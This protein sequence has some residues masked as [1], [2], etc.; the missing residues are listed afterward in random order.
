MFTERSGGEKIWLY[1]A[2]DERDEAQF[3]V[4]QILTA[5]RDEGRAYG[6]YA[7]FY[8]TNAQSRPFEEE[9]LKYNVPYVVVGG[10]RFYERAEVK[11]ALA[12]LRAIVNPTDPMALRR[13]VN[14]PPRG[15]GKATLERAETLA[16][17]R[18][19]TLREE[20]IALRPRLIAGHQLVEQLALALQPLIKGQDDRVTHRLDARGWCIAAAQPPGQCLRRIG[21]ALRDELVFAVADAP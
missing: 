11:D 21:K 10:V 16:A 13:I 12:Y 20:D 4:R 9:L 1:E 7:V 19:L 8:R 14:S 3:V 17:E 18:G 6:E 5:A 2:S 15:I